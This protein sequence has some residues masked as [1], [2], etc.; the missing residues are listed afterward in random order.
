MVITL[1]PNPA[2]D[3]TSWVEQLQPGRVNRVL[4]THIDPAGKGINVS[5]MVHRLKWPTIAFG[6]VAG[7]TG[8][9]VTKALEVEGVQH[10]FVRIPGQTRISVTIRDSLSQATSFFG[11][12]PEIPPSSLASL[13]NLLRFWLQAA[14]VL[15]LAG[16]LPPGVP[17]DIYASYV[18]AAQERGVKVILDADGA[19]LRN[20]V[21]AQPDIVKPNVAEAER[22]VGRKLPDSDAILLAARTLAEHGA[23]IVVVSMGA[24]GAICV[25]RER[26]WHVLP[27]KVERRSTVGAGDAMVAGLAVALARGEDIEHGLVL[28]TAAGAATA[29]TPGTAQGAAEDVCRLLPQVQ[30]EALE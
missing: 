17:D 4:N 25:N 15:V 19:A 14:H 11:S 16:S 8:D 21:S 7:E 13:G 24:A 2:V 23:G 9:L 1:T 3:Q 12:G 29:M 10:H 18:R 20:G 30:I 5:R 26:A 22:L 6:F 28:G 27:P